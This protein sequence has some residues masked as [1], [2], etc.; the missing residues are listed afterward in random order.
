MMHL[1]LGGASL[2]GQ[3]EFRV[4]DADGRGIPGAALVSGSGVGVVS[5]AE[6]WL[7]LEAGVDLDSTVWGV[8][9]LGFIDRTMGGRELRAATE[10]RLEEAVL[11]LPMALVEAV[12]LTGG[13]PLAVPGAVT[14]LSAKALQRQGDTDIHRALRTV[15]GVYIQEED[16][17]GL[18]PNIGLRGSGSER[19][20]RI[21]ILEDGIPIAPAPYTAPAA[22]Y[23]PSVGRMAGIEVMKG[24]S[25]IAHG[26]NTIGGA[27]NFISTPIP[28]SFSGRVDARYGHFG[29]GRM[30]FHVGDG[31][32]R[33]GWLVEAMRMG[34]GGFKVLDDGGDT[35]FDKLDLLGKLS[36]HSDG[37]ARRAQ[38]VELKL[39]TVG[40]QSNETY[41]GLTAAD[42]ASAPFRRYAGSGRDRM[43]SRQSQGILTHVLDLGMGWKWTARAWATGFGRNWYKADRVSGADGEWVKLPA[44]FEEENADP[45]RME[46]LDVFR[47]QS[48]GR[49]RLKANNRSYR[50]R[51]A[52]A[53]LAWK[54]SGTGWQETE[55]SVRFHKDGMDRFQWTDDWTMSGGVLGSPEF[56]VPGT[57]SNRIEWS[58]AWSG[59]ARARWS[60]NG[61][62]WIPGIRTEQILAQRE[63]YGTSDADRTGAQLQVRRNVATAWLPGLGFQRSFG[64]HWSAF[65]GVHRGFLPPGS[66]EG[67]LPET[68]WSQELGLRCWKP[69]SEATMVGFGHLGR[70]LQGTDAASSGG[71]GE[72]EIFNGGSTR[73]LGLEALVNLTNGRR[74]EE[75]HRWELGLTYT[76]TDARF[77]TDFVSD[78]EAWGEVE[79]GDALPYLPRHQ[80]TLRAGWAK[81][82]WSFDGAIRRS[83]GMRT[84][85]GSAPIA[86]V[87]SVGGGTLVDATARLSLGGGCRFELSGRNLLDS[88]YLASARPAGLRPGMPRT[89]AAGFNVTF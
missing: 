61:W 4:V 17:F 53:R 2:C 58:R 42:F 33:I 73:V 47:G 20:G 1:L 71:T 35:G 40:E 29:T 22:Y 60:R 56:G 89:L 21:S 69:R 43:E 78:Y 38:R 14:V 27:I 39:G 72:G 51:G 8:R 70:N 80:G 62:T 87:A 9:C 41:A 83:G 10:I 23:F 82:V 32:G 45:V 28:S 36:W 6:G 66:G 11:D 34:S 31:S 30:H 18:R 77:T 15:P 68:A 16:G 7:R 55:M 24:A 44:L 63:D 79:A 25:Q 12:S 86:Q 57:E 81:G 37:G 76:F 52:E 74:P 46:A 49:V 75:G 54:G 13:R 84:V 59:H 64:A 48:L 19:S 3:V 65:G 26:P 5:D 85:A 50:T 88:V 67:V